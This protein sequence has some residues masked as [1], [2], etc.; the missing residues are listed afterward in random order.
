M[1]AGCAVGS[2]W[3]YRRKTA[4]RICLRYCKRNMPLK[5][6]SQLL[7]EKEFIESGADG[8]D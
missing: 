8:E 1:G 3:D 7:Q 2:N 4:Q 5:L 6:G